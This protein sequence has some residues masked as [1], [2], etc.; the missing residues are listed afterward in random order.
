MRQMLGITYDESDYTYS[1]SSRFSAEHDGVRSIIYG[2]GHITGFGTSWSWIFDH[3][4]QHLC[5]DNDRAS[6]LSTLVYDGLLKNRN[7]FWWTLDSQVS[8]SH[9]DTV[10][11]FDNALQVVTVK[12]RWFFNL[13]HD[14]RF[15]VSFRDL[16]INN[17]TDFF[18]VLRALNK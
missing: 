17:A 11:K 15:E 14:T 16:G 18:N 4:F 9:H 8:T 13:C 12:T 6:V 2:R 10:A 7:I 5:C 3:T 1:S